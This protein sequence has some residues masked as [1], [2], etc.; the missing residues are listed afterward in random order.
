MSRFFQV[1]LLTLCAVPVF[2]AGAEAERQILD[3]AMG[4]LSTGTAWAS[5]E[6]TPFE[7]LYLKKVFGTTQA[8]GIVGEAFAVRYI[9][10]E[11][12]NSG[13][14]T[15]LNPRNAPQGLDHL[16]VKYDKNMRPRSLLVG[17]TKFGSS[18]LSTTRD[19]VRQGSDKWVRERLSALGKHYDGIAAQK[20]IIARKMPL[21]AESYDVPLR[22]GKTASFWRDRTAGNAWHY[23]GPPESL[24]E[25]RAT[26]KRTGVFLLAAGEERIVY[27]NRLFEVRTDGSDIVLT[28]KDL[29]P[30]N[31]GV[32]Q[33]KLPMLDE[34]RVKNALNRQI[35]EITKELRVSIAKNLE[36]EGMTVPET[37]RAA[38]KVVTDASVKDVLR[39]PSAWKT[40]ARLSAVPVASVATGLLVDSGLQYALNGDVNFQRL[41]VDSSVMTG[42]VL[43]PFAWQKLKPT[44]LNPTG[45]GARLVGSSLVGLL[46]TAAVSYGH[47]A[48]GD[49]TLRDANIQTLSGG[50]GVVASVL[51]YQAAMA[52]VSTWGTAMTGTPI[53]A[54][55]GAA[56]SNAAGAWFGFGGALGMSATTVG[57]IVVTGSVIV[58]AT[59]VSGAVIYAVSLH[60]EK[61]ENTR[62]SRLLDEYGRPSVMERL[63]EQERKSYRKAL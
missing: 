51:A 35:P 62:I 4:A 20:E 32:S 25:A 9:S 60:D 39:S 29:K 63:I 12:K 42:A 24:A 36:R 19:G 50:A 27:R 18:K 16:Y 23:D 46:A 33:E 40:A 45:V 3:K 53:A 31:N 30:L 14:W 21:S 34:W 26:A 48:A 28:S 55:H 8:K 59:L 7:Q 13:N 52:G 1:F 10:A 47:Y 56:A 17:E 6:L 54:L 44:S 41:A 38:E 49:G 5:S 22:N 15:G 2:V 61:K 37:N 43:S 11:L 57:T 58:V